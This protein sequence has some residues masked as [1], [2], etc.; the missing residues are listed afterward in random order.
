[1]LIKNTCL[2]TMVTQC[3]KVAKNVDECYINNYDTPNV[4]V[5]VDVIIGWYSFSFGKSDAKNLTVLNYGED[6]LDKDDLI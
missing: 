3:Q 1:M 4:A 6:D 5:S 2:T